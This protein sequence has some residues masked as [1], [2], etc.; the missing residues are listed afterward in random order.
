MNELEVD[1]VA[2]TV[3]VDFAGVGISITRCPE[4]FPSQELGVG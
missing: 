3:L 2:R 1:R 4:Q